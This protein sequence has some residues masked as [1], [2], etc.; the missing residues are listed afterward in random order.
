MKILF[1][2]IA[3]EINLNLDSAKS[4]IRIAVAWFTNEDLFNKLC[5]KLNEGVTV[6]LLIIND[7]IN[8]NDFGLDFQRFIDLGG[9]F[10]FGAPDNLMHH[11]FCIIDSKILINGSYNWTYFAEFKNLENIIIHTNSEEIQP[12]NFEF[13]R[14]IGGLSVIERVVRNTDFS[15]LEFDLTSKNIVSDDISLKSFKYES[16][17]DYSRAVALARRAMELNPSSQSFKKQFNNLQLK[18]ANATKA[19]F[20]P[21]ATIIKSEKL[22][23][24]NSSLKEGIKA[25]KK[26]Q[27]TSAI[28]YFKK[29][30]SEN[31]DFAE[32]YYWIGLCNWKLNESK[33]VI[34]A[35]SHAILINPKYSIAFNL[36]GIAYSEQG[37]LEQAISDFT[38]AIAYQYKLFKAY[39]NRGLIYKRKN[40]LLKSSSDFNKTIELLNTILSENPTDEEALAIR[41]D[42]LSLTNQNSKAKEDYTNAKMIYDKRLEDEK[43][44]NFE[45]RIRDGL[46][47]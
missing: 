42:A 21:S 17:G 46:L 31:S 47:R 33:E 14:I 40:E 13:N 26:K 3:K 18:Q 5:S 45:D 4:N 41:G 32:I 19:L 1:K 12:F 2:N 39:F 43:D 24:F 23:S 34:E 6:E 22:I 8:N 38:D 29:A 20:I 35:C 16:I 11:K 7:F 36:R 10:Y 44:F 9:K 25:Y 28:Q 37:N 27:F 30:L 15:F